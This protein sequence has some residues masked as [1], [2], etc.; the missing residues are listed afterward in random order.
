[1]YINVSRPASGGT[2]V[3]RAIVAVIDLGDGQSFTSVDRFG[4]IRDESI[5]SL[6]DNGDF[7]YAGRFEIGH[8]NEDGNGWLVAHMSVRNPNSTII[9]ATETMDG[10]SISTLGDDEIGDF[11]FTLN[12]ARYWSVELNRIF[13]LEPYKNGVVVEPFLGVKYIEFKDF[14]EDGEFLTTTAEIDG[15]LDD[16]GIP[17]ETISVSGDTI[18]RAN[19]VTENNLLGGLFGMRIHRRRARWVLSS[20]IRALILSNFQKHSR[21]ERLD[22]FIQEDDGDAVV[23]ISRTTEERNFNELV[24]GGELRAQAAFE[25]S[26]DVSIRFTFDLIHLGQGVARGFGDDNNEQLTMYGGSVGFSVNR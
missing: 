14:A 6:G 20:E 21:R 9:Q 24:A 17:T 26:R 2:N 19:S 1:M 16:E 4:N 5:L 7:T 11:N 12:S 15:E 10:G 22:S 8:V 13:R 18:L 23:E 25:I 3:S